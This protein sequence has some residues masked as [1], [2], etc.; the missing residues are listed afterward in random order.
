MNPSGMEESVQIMD[1][2]EMEFF[3]QGVLQGWGFLF[4]LE[5]EAKG[6]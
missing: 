3:S 5:R 4:L 1:V 2:M 6:V